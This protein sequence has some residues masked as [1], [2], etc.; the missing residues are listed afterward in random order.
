[1]AVKPGNSPKN[2]TS[3]LFRK[4]NL[5]ANIWTGDRERENGMWRTRYN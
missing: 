5:K 2:R 1:M 3:E 4:E